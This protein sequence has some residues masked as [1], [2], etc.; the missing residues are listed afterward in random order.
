MISTYVELAETSP[1]S[2][3]SLLPGPVVHL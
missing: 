1:K 3:I 2:S